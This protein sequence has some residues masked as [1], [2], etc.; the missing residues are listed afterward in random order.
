MG[1][2]GWFTDPALAGGGA[3]IDMGIHA[4][5]TVRFI[6]G[7]PK[8]ESVYASIGTYHS[9]NAVDDSGFIVVNWSSGIMSTIQ[10]GWWQPYA[11][12]VVATTR[13]LGQRGSAKLLPNRIG[14]VDPETQTIEEVA[15]LAND[16]ANL[17]ALFEQMYLGQLAAFLKCIETGSKP[18]PGADE[19][20]VNMCIVDAAYQS[21][22]SG[23]V[24]WMEEELP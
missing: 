22:R 2:S 1:S 24:V 18:M 21:S 7:D 15:M 16:L 9:D 12:G 4:I 8:P 20:L 23:E 14:R 17:D 19:G 3:L 6:L 10:F 13:I 11:T 5:D